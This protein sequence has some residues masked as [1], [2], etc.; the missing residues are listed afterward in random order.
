MYIGPKSITERPRRTKISTEVGHVARDS[1]TTFKVKRS[2]VNLQ[3]AG[4][5]VAASRTACLGR[6]TA[7][8][9]RVGFY[10]R[11]VGRRMVVARS[12]CSRIEVES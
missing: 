4:R 12:N 2:K 9:T 8:Q 6:S 5:I 3:G 1:D 10:G 11:N 7:A